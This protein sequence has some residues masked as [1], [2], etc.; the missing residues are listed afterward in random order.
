MLQTHSDADSVL[1]CHEYRLETGPEIWQQAAN[2]FSIKFD[3]IALSSSRSSL[4]V[5]I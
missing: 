5:E 1:P 2:L 4:V 3:A